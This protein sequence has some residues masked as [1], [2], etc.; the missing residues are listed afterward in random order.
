MKVIYKR[1][2]TFDECVQI[3]SAKSRLKCIGDDGPPYC[4]DDGNQKCLICVA[5]SALCEAGGILQE[6]TEVINGIRHNTK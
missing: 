4:N 6:A 3:L 2:F 1:I 5:R